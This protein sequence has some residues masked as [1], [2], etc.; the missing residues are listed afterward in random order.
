MLPLFLP[1]GVTFDKL[2]RAQVAIIMFVAAYIAEVVR[3]GLQAI[4]KGQFEAAHSLGLGYWRMMG[5]IILPQALRI[6]IPPLVNI[7]IAL[8]KD[9]S[10]VLA[11]GIFDVMTLAKNATIEPAWRGFGLEAFVFVSLIYFMF[12]FAMSKY[13]QGIE[14]DLSRA[15]KR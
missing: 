11:I 14:A 5:F 1:A 6:V 4:P 3:G 9:T 12:C 15:Q 8:F 13:S 7:F 10:L 2:L